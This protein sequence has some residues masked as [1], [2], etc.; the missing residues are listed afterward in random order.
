[1]LIQNNEPSWVHQQAEKD[2]LQVVLLPLPPFV[3]ASEDRVRTPLS[4]LLVCSL[5]A[6]AHG[7]APAE[8]SA[9]DRAFDT[10][11]P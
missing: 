5:T 4:L 9:Q 3:P 6:L 2:H 10:A 11:W 7:Q 1:P 8:A